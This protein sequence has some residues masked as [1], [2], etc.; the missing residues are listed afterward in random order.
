[1]MASEEQPG[2]TAGRVRTPD[3]TDIGYIR[4][5]NTLNFFKLLLIF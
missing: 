1:M 2:F 4:I 5:V 3:G